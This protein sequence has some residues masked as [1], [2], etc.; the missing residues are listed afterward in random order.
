MAGI[1]AIGGHDPTC[2]AGVSAD[3]EA[4]R[5]FGVTPLIVVSA[6]TAQTNHSGIEAIE[7]V[8]AQILTAQVEAATR[9]IA[10]TNNSPIKIGLL[11]D[12]PT[13]KVITKLLG[14][15]Q[16]IRIID[17]VAS[18]SAGGKQWASKRWVQ[19]FVSLL[20]P[21]CDLLT[22]N[23]AEAQLLAGLP[24][25]ASATDCAKQLRKLGFKRIL[26]TD[27]LGPA[28]KIAADELVSSFANENFVLSRQKIK[29]KIRRGTG[30][31]LSSAIAAAIATGCSINEAVV[32]GK[33]HV[34]GY[35]GSH[36]RGW[37]SAVLMPQIKP[38][39][40]IIPDQPFAKLNSPLGVC[41]ITESA[42]MIKNY[43][44]NGFTAAQLR[45]KNQTNI[46]QIA[47]ALNTTTTN[48]LRLFINDYWQ[49]GLK[50]SKIYGVHLGQ[51]DLKQA[52]LVKL[53]QAGLR[54]GVSA[55]NWFELA[56]A[57]SLIPSYVSVGPVF[58]PNGKNLPALGL[59]R[60]RRMLEKD[61]LATTIAIGGIGPD[62]F[63]SLAKMKLGGIATIS[64]TANNEQAKDLLDRWRQAV[65]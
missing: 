54:L 39:W 64:A 8:S 24:D 32:L 46:K 15:W 48:K 63:I 43:A 27:Y 50:L 13:I 23:L 60:L 2:G 29:S 40:L 31:R 35:C 38:A 14:N 6:V 11:P 57:R 7:P 65:T 51:E 53:Q 12:I 18:A 20:A 55:H 33:M 9:Q 25:T 21:V 44:N 3:Q 5:C 16:G 58:F 34:T 45:C 30:C 56:L 41:P 36:Q 19:A 17:P 49:L 42:T 1:I 26:L 4:I 47:E 52:D 59:T 28:A 37:P 10:K 22:P 61:K 62:N